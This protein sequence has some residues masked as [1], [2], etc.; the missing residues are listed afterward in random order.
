[1]VNAI[2]RGSVGHEGFVR[3]NAVGSLLHS[4]R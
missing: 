2:I 4:R 1:M 3:C